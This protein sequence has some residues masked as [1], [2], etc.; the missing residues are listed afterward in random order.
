MLGSELPGSVFWPGT[1]DADGIAH[2]SRVEPVH[3]LSCLLPAITVQLAPEGRLPDGFRQQFRNH[4]AAFRVAEAVAPEPF[5][6]AYGHGDH[7]SG[8]IGVSKNRA[9]APFE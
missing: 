3:D 2:K 9:E 8:V 5:T 1:K 4:H 7:F 6:Q